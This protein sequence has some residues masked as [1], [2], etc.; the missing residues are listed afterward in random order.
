SEGDMDFS[1]INSNIANWIKNWPK[2]RTD[3]MSLISR[4][5]I[6]EGWYLNEVLLVGIYSQIEDH[7]DFSSMIES[8]L[9][10]NWD[11]FWEAIFKSEP[12]RFSLFSEA[13]QCF[14]SSLYGASI[15]L[16]FSQADGVFHD[17]F[18]KSLYKKEGERAKTEADV[19][20]KNV[21]ARESL[22]QLI[23]QFKD[24]SLLRR[25]F[26]EVYKEMFSV[27]GAD[28]MKNIDPAHPESTLKTPNRHGVLHG[29][30]KEYASETNALKVFSMFLFVL[31]AIHG[32]RMME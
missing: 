24:A 3:D 12:S 15:H 5:A 25:M 11:G 28:P 6:S 7:D 32:E 9:L 20:L 18:G 19:H 27:I 14:E 16:F 2:A 13:K 21:I 29:I 31:Y 4:S 26:N 30:H 22:A 23:N 17:H 10:E 8:L 1:T